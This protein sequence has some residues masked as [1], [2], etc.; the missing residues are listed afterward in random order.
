MK[1][2]IAPAAGWRFGIALAL[3]IVTVMGMV[4]IVCAKDDDATPAKKKLTG[5]QLFT[6]NC[7]RCHTE[8]YPTEFS[9][10]QWKTLLMHMRVR[11]NLP[12][13]QAQAI[14]NYMLENK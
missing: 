10:V 6:I 13:A 3:V 12:P 4:S 2:C 11:A 1:R 5:E 7:S 14:Y 8:R 9:K